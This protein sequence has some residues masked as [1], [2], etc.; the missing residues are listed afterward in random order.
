MARLSWSQQQVRDDFLQKM[1]DG[2][3][4]Q[5]VESGSGLPNLA[6]TSTDFFALERATVFHDNWV[7]AGFA[8]ELRQPGDMLPVEIA[9]QPVLLLRDGDGQIRAFHNVCRHRGARLVETRR[10]AK[11]IVCPNHAWSYGLRGQLIARPHFYGGDQ[12]DVNQADCHR[13]DLVPIRCH[14]WHDWIFI[15]LGG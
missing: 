4:E 8:H 9:G 7:F 12:H 13:A 5:A 3:L 2:R 15:D 6:Y 11:K 14:L 10:N 1:R